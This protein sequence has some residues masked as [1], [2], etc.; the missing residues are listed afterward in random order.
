M[1]ADNCHR[2]FS[3][4]FPTTVVVIRARG[5]NAKVL[6]TKIGRLYLIML[7]VAVAITIISVDNS[8]LQIQLL[9]V[10]GCHLLSLCVDMFFRC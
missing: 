3:E 5:K 1:I 9:L 7:Q 8:W 2:N 6:L 10:V 4:I